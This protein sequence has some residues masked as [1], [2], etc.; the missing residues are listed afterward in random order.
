MAHTHSHTDA[1]TNPGCAGAILRSHPERRQ[2]HTAQQTYSTEISVSLS[3][4]RTTTTT[5]PLRWLPKRSRTPRGLG[6]IFALHFRR[7]VL[8]FASSSSSQPKGSQCRMQ[9]FPL[10][11]CV[12]TETRAS[13]SAVRSI[14]TCVFTFAITQKAKVGLGFLRLC[15]F[16]FF[17]VC[18][19]CVFV[20]REICLIKF[21]RR[22]RQIRNNTRGLAKHSHEIDKQ[23]LLNNSESRSTERR[24][25]RINPR[26]AI[27]LC[28]V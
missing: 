26:R 5:P 17:W 14:P 3:T 6:I 18:V 7:S 9:C 22:R 24:N 8:G 21:R 15:V 28:C 1:A 2:T 12:D 4:G 23:C 13:W 19:C 20:S 16:D 10:K 11:C 25:N 27:L